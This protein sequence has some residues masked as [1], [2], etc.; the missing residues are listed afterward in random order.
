MF[1][2][3][4]AA[5]RRGA[6]RHLQ[7]RARAGVHT[8]SVVVMATLDSKGEES[9]FVARAARAAGASSQLQLTKLKRAG[10]Q[11][12]DRGPCAASSAAA[13]GDTTVKHKTTKN[14]R[15]D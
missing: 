3:L 5:L 7:G 8:N 14:K 4:A 1:A 9:R 13:L 15:G 12:A 10:L 6:A 2:P 11:G